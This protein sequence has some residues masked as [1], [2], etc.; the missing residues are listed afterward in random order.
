MREL[1]LAHAAIRKADPDAKLAGFCLTTDFNVNG[2]PWLGQCGKLGGF[3]YADILSFHP[4]ASPQL[5]SL[6]PADEDIAN[7]RKVLKQ[8][9]K[10]DMP[11]VN[12][13]LYWLDKL[14]A[15]K[16][17]DRTRWTDEVCSPNQII[18]RTLIDLGEGVVQSLALAPHRHMT[19]PLLIPHRPGRFIEFI[20][21]EKFVVL[22]TLA[23]LFE[24]AKPV[25]KYRYDNGVVCYVFRDQHK[26]LIAGIWNYQGKAG[27]SA[28]LSAFQVMDFFGNEEA[29][30]IKELKKDVPYLFTPGKLSESDFLDKIKN[31]KPVLDNPV[32]A[33]EFGRLAGDTLFVMLHNSADKP[34]EATLGLN[35]AGLVA[36]KSVKAEIPAKGKIA[37]EIPVK[38]RDAAIRDAAL[39][40]RLNGNFFRREIKI[41][42]NPVIDGAFEGKNFKGTLKFGNGEIRMRLT[43]QDATDAGPTGKRNPWDTDCAEL[44]FDTDPLFIP[45]THGQVYTPNTFRIFITPRDGKLTAQGIDPAVCKHSV[46][47]EKDSYTVELSF[48]AKTGKY[49]GFECKIDDFDAAGKR[50]GETQIGEGAELYKKRGSF[51]LAKEK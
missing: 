10:P 14:D 12:S 32:F 49:L 35:G 8:Y 20:P 50:V 24:R 30:G 9:G 1:K 28:D 44:F 31:L 27:L 37:V 2:A 43:V 36:R 25:G 15:L 26:K 16:N 7:L 45:E 29:P 33:G 46:K 19:K 48:P 41:V 5:G 42:R 18:T 51:G 47:C 23:R 4:Y 17:E 13:E 3:E 34:V 39:V 11:L 21:S 40:I 38:V 22:N 6:K